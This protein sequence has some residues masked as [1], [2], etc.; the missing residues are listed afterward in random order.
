MG[1]GVLPLSVPVQHKRYKDGYRCRFEYACC[2][3]WRAPYDFLR[4]LVNLHG[5]S[6][7]EARCCRERSLRQMAPQASTQH[8]ICVQCRRRV[9]RHPRCP[10]CEA[11]IHAEE[12][13]Q[14]CCNWCRAHARGARERD[15]RIWRKLLA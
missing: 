3:R 4:H 6:W 1:S 8:I 9:S 10:R 7:D 14:P 12:V 11:L 2:D 5:V 13:G 15:W